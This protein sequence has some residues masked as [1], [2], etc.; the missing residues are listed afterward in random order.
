MTSSDEVMTLAEIRMKVRKLS[1]AKVKKILARLDDDIEL[2]EKYTSEAGRKIWGKAEPG[3][4]SRDYLKR[5]KA[6]REVVMEEGSKS[7]D[8][9]K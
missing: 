5:L 7:Y 9:R 6:M 3:Q 4:D 2:F 8:S 1:P